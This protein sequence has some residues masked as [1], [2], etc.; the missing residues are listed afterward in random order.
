MFIQMLF[1]SLIDLLC[2]PELVLKLKSSATNRSI[3]NVSLGT[4]PKATFIASKHSV[5]VHPSDFHTTVQLISSAIQ[6]A[7]PQAKPKEISAS[8]EVD[9]FAGLKD[10]SQER[11][12]SVKPFWRTASQQTRRDLLTLPVLEL[13]EEARHES[14]AYEEMIRAGRSSFTPTERHP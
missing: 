11:L 13:L 7:R 12:E 3:V 8:K 10:D 5:I 14:Q 9:P 2:C 6:G 4:S 1:S